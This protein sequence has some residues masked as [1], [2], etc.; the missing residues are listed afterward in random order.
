MNA[1]DNVAA[2]MSGYP[3]ITLRLNTGMISQIIPKAGRIKM[4][5][6]GCPKNQNKCCQKITLPCCCG[7]KKCAPRNRSK[8][9]ITCAPV[10]TGKASNTNMP[11]VNMSHTKSGMRMNVMPGQR[12]HK[13]VAMKLMAVVILPNPLT[14]IPRIQ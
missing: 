6:S 4:Y 11:T 10:S 5:T 14:M 13:M 8:S 12:M 3:K 1:M 2:T 7:S 9:N